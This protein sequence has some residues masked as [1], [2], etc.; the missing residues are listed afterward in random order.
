MSKR[1][2]TKERFFTL[3]DRLRTT[4]DRHERE[5]IKKELARITFGK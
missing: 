3:I 1:Q 4:K 2:T 5:R